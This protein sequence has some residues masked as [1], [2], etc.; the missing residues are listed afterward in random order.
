MS[1]HIL[2]HQFECSNL[3]RCSLTP[4]SREAQRKQIAAATEVYLAKGKTITPVPSNVFVLFDQEPVQILKSGKK[5]I[6]K[7]IKKAA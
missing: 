1:L 6:S 4:S 3:T 2:I 7:N 5:V